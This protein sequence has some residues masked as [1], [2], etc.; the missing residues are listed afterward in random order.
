MFVPRVQQLF[1]L[2]FRKDLTAP[3]KVY[4][5]SWGN[6]EAR[7]APPLMPDILIHTWKT[8]TYEPPKWLFPA[9]FTPNLT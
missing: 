7:G 8:A 6:G 5:K 1:P 2:S 3:E 9:M 4:N